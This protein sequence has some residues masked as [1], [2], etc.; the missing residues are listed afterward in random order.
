[1]REEEEKSDWKTPLDKRRTIVML[2]IE[3]IFKPL[4]HANELR[5]DEDFFILRRSRWIQLTAIH[6]VCSFGLFRLLAIV[7]SR[8]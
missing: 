4:V 1:M 3:H 8:S 7:Q 6:N 5:G 2:N